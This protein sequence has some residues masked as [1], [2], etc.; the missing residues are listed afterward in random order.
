MKRG[1][2]PKYHSESERLEARREASRRFRERERKKKLFGIEPQKEDL[3]MPSLCEWCLT[4]HY[5]LSLEEI[6]QV[7]PEIDCIDCKALVSRKKFIVYY[8]SKKD[9]TVKNMGN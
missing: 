5:G 2:K 1:R 9:E 4:Q 8:R 3:I 7:N 6:E